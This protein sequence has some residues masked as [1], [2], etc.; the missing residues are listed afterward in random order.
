LAGEA[1]NESGGRAT[2]TRQAREGS[3]PSLAPA[4]ALPDPREAEPPID[5][6][7]TE[8]ERLTTVTIRT[9]P[10]PVFVIG[11]PRSGTSVLPW[12]LAHHSDFWTSHE[13]EFIHGL[14]GEGQ[15]EHVYK[16]LCSKEPGFITHHG[17]YRKE[18]F[19]A[20]GLGINALI[21]S[22]SEGRRWI[23][24]SPGYTTMAWLLADMF[25]G[26]Y[27]IHVLR[28]GRAVVNSML[29]FADVDGQANAENLPEWATD[30]DAAV[31]TWRHYVGEALEFCSS[32]PDRSLTVKNEDLVERPEEEFEKILTFLGASNN[33]EPAQFFRT[34]RINSSFG[35]EIWGSGKVAEKKG[36][37]IRRGS[38]AKAWRDWS[39][40]QRATFTEVAGDL[41]QSLGY[42]AELEGED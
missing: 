25:P 10:N 20:L 36:E 30:F 29:H 18:F 39:A 37:V 19:G 17:V 12:S 16:T 22:R 35:Q 15:P 1:E 41:L 31:E 11:S 9:C 24:Q 23:D 32:K 4:P 26:S 21:S 14:F 38:A 28:D 33:T 2:G 6:G 27:F 40:E 42:P 7:E 13:T 8:K 3:A 34:S 5:E